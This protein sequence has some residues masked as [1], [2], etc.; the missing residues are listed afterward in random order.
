M[1]SV[2]ASARTCARGNHRPYARPEVGGRRCRQPGQVRKEA[3]TTISCR[4]VGFHRSP[5]RAPPPKSLLMEDAESPGL[6]LDLPEVPAPAAAASP[7]RVLA[8][9]YRPQ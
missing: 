2:L 1:K 8:R 3:A 9:K 7:Y 6:G 5:C 4:V